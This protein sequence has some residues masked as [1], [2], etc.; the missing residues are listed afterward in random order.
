M[1]QYISDEIGALVVKYVHHNDT[2]ALNKIKENHLLISLLKPGT[3]IFLGTHVSSLSNLTLYRL[4]II[5]GKEPEESLNN[6][7][8]EHVKR[9]GD[10]TFSWKSNSTYDYATK[11]GIDPWNKKRSYIH[12]NRIEGFDI[13]YIS[14]KK[15]TVVA[16]LLFYDGFNIYQS[17]LMQFSKYGEKWYMKTPKDSW[18]RGI[19]RNI[20]VLYN[21]Q[22]Y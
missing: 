15:N 16:S 4:G 19:E 5:Q 2:Y 10:N 17:M 12:I 21:I 7:Q 20:N 6:S 22:Q 13:E 14:V 18:F 3:K 11:N 8:W 1:L 9:G